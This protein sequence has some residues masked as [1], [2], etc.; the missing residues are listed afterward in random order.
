[1]GFQ[2][3]R[4]NIVGVEF[5]A[6]QLFRDMSTN[7][8]TVLN[9]NG[10]II[11]PGPVTIDETVT[12]ILMAPTEDV[13]AV[14]IEE[15]ESGHALF[16]HR[17]PWRFAA[18]IDSVKQTIRWYVCTP[19]NIKMNGENFTVAISADSSSGTDPVV[20]TMC[21]TG[22]LTTGSRE[23]S[24]AGVDPDWTGVLKTGDVQKY[25]FRFEHFGFD[26]TKVDRQ[27]LP[28][29]YR[30]SISDH[31]IAFCM[32][33]EARDSSGDKFH[34]FNIQ[35][36]VDKDTGVPVIGDEVEDEIGKAPL[37]CVFSMTGGGP[38]PG[39]PS[40][41]VN[42]DSNV[43][44]PEGAYYFVVRESDVHAPTFPRSATVDSPDSA[45]IIN[46]VQQVSISEDNKLVISSMKGMNSQRY[47]YPHEL[48]MITYVSADVV[49][50]FAD[51]NVRMYG[52]AED[53]GYK[54]LKANYSNNKG[55]RILM[56]QKGASIA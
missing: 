30:L 19:T 23:I 31:G 39:T 34:W 33:V 47:A 12:K 24:G 27:A 35:R 26:I 48:D 3:E 9:L 16:A 55:M 54:A 22:L 42:I 15:S 10:A 51:I 52:E 8:F 28:L 36:M 21:R 6:A 17:Q 53:R 2:V 4:N 45:R 41:S 13:D 40:A 37:F 43:A 38:T 25:S 5:L 50:Q 32:W 1:M 11:P 7:G 44:N 56:L 46:T 20:R 14:A 18:E 29:S 49:S